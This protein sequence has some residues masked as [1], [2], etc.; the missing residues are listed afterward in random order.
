[1]SITV[2][3]VQGN[4]KEAAELIAVLEAENERMRSAA[5]RLL[6]HINDL[7]PRSHKWPGYKELTEAVHQQNKDASK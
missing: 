4:P 6:D 2:G 5:Q 1:M 7:F 3:Q